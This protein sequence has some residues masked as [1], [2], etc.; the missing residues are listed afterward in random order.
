MRLYIYMRAC[1]YY[2]LTASRTATGL[3]RHSR[4][5]FVSPARQRAMVQT[6]TMHTHDPSKLAVNRT[7]DVTALL[8]ACR[9]MFS[10]CRD[11]N[12]IVASV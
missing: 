10:L 9:G 3:Q 4:V 6:V 12:F 2:G 11:G 8:V 7:K 5:T 1:A